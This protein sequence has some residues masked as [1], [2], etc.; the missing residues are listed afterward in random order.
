MTLPTET[1]LFQQIPGRVSPFKRLAAAVIFQAVKDATCPGGQRLGY[2]QQPGSFRTVMGSLFGV[3]SWASIQ[4]RLGRNFPTCWIPAWSDATIEFQ[5]PLSH[6]R[7]TLIVQ[8]SS[9]FV[10]GCVRQVNYHEPY[11]LQVA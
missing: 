4:I 5:S 1:R 2:L 9:R 10:T 11:S 8:Q 6:K 7:M 3:V